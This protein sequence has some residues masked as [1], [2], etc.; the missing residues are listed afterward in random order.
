MSETSKS[1]T[2]RN[3]R[4]SL[5]NFAK[6]TFWTMTCYVVTYC[7]CSGFGQYQP[8]QSGEIRWGFGMS[9][10]DIVIWSP[11]EAN[12]QKY[13]TSSGTQSSRGNL[14]GYFYSP[15][16]RLDRALIHPTQNYFGNEDL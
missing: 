11:F 5:R 6:A 12:W 7:F 16:I 3:S 4:F 1:P 10:T 15:L 9:V 13:T 2:V 14:L 8:A